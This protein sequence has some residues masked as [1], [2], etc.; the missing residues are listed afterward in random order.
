MR[1]GRFTIEQLSEGRFELFGNKRINR[2]PVDHLSPPGDISAGRR[3]LTGINPVYI[4]DGTFH[5]LLDAGLGWGL[6][7]GSSYSDISNICTNLDV[8]GVDPEEI[9][10][11]VFSHLHYDHAA[12]ASYIN[13][14]A[15]TRPTFPNA[16][17]ILQKQEWDYALQAAV[18]EKAG[19][20]EFYHLDEFYRLYADGYLTLSDYPRQELLPGIT[21]IRTGGHTPGHQIVQITDKEHTAYYLGD[22]IPTALQLNCHD[23]NTRNTH[24]QEAQKAKRNI[25]TTAYAEKAYLLF[26][27]SIHS[28]IGQL[29]KDE[30]YNFV[31]REV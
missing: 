25:L 22:L 11:V 21:L 23:E 1:L 5:L 3:Q 13:H 10:H 29:E 8:F 30:E 28:K 7:A 31:F 6:D 24:Q 19:G 15:H 12:G 20:D 9:T 17:Y 2:S 18:A 27:H 26:Y 16:D 4:T 14:S